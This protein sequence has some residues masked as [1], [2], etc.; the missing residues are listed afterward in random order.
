MR[1]PRAAGEV[2]AGP[3]P[4]ELHVP[5]PPVRCALRTLALACRPALAAPSGGPT[6]KRGASRVRRSPAR[7]EEQA[8]AEPFSSGLAA[9]WWADYR[10][11]RHALG[12]ARSVVAARPTDQLGAA[13]RG[14]RDR[15]ANRPVPRSEVSISGSGPWR[16]R[17]A[18]WTLLRSGPRAGGRGCTGA[19]ARMFGRDPA[20]PPIRPPRR[21]IRTAPGWWPR[22][23]AG[24]PRNPGR[25]LPAGAA[26]ARVMPGLPG[27][28]AGRDPTRRLQGSRA[29]GAASRLQFALG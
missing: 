21:W 3:A 23:P 19:L 18:G 17:G 11:A 25:P 4:G 7:A 13:V 10:P 12:R 29:P 14:S 1:A 9:T 26:G 20:G 22:R 24:A 15:L 27:E 28:S 2:R 8:P 16:G 5:V 6:R